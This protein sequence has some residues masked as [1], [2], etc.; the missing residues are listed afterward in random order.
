MTQMPEAVKKRRNSLAAKHIAKQGWKSSDISYL[1]D[2]AFL[3]GF[4]AAYDILAPVVEATEIHLVNAL[5]GMNHTKECNWWDEWKQSCD[6]PISDVK[7]ALAALQNGG[8]K[9]G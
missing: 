7:R 8:K 4:E 2:K 3:A 1:Q 9:D 5:L 6:C